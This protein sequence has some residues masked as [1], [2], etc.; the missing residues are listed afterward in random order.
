[1][2]AY[3]VV[4]YSVN[5]LKSLNIF[6]KVDQIDTGFLKSTSGEIHVKIKHEY[7]QIFYHIQNF[8]KNNNVIQF[9]I[10]KST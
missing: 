6:S 3:S 10:H 7:K 5:S 1:M 2:A 4:T 8:K 9:N